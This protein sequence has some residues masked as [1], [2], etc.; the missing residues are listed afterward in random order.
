MQLGVRRLSVI[1]VVAALAVAAVGCGSTG[2]GD[3][4]GQSDST[5]TT[6]TVVST[7]TAPKVLERP[8]DKTVWWEGFEISVDDLKAEP[9]AGS[10]VNVTIDVTWTNLV[11]RVRVPAAADARLRRRGHHPLVGRGRGRRPGVGGRAR[12]PRTS[13]RR[14]I[15]PR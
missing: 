15:R 14:P 3:D 7:T 10:G 5:T 13:P 8:I 12:S 2:D 9:Q 1:A 6:T 11:R 4:E